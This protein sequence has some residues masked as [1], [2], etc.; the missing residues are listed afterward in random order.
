MDVK[1]NQ[2]LETELTPEEVTEYFKP[3]EEKTEEKFR[4]G[5]NIDDSLTEEIHEFPTPQQSRLLF[6]SAC[7]FASALFLC[8]AFIAGTNLSAGSEQTAAALEQLRAVSS[9]YHDVTEKKNEL[10]EEVRKLSDEELDSQSTAN[11]LNNFDSAKKALE[12]KLNTAKADFQ[13]KNDELYEINAALNG[14]DESA[15]TIKLEPGEY[16]V[17]ADI[18]EGTFSVTGNGSIIA[19]T[20]ANEAVINMQLSDSPNIVVLKTGYTVKINCTAEFAASAE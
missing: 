15:Y 17:G 14:I 7:V 9:E 5:F 13:K 16:S 10:T 11:S 6:V 20:S 1:E 12:E 19:S 2:T 8:T 18:P 3:D 4:F